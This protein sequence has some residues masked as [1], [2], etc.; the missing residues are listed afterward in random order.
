M[1]MCPY[2][3]G[4]APDMK[5]L[6]SVCCVNEGHPRGVGHQGHVLVLMLSRS[7][8]SYSLQPHGL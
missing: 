6:G 1:K 5:Y 7:E 3:S 8:V 4:M 2:L